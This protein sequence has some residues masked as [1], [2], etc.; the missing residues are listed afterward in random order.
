MGG[1]GQQQLKMSQLK[2]S[3]L[4][5]RGGRVKSIETMSQNM[6]FFFSGGFPKTNI[7][8]EEMTELFSECL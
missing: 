4:G 6:Q 7:L 5:L 2:L 8:M 3:Q 1:R